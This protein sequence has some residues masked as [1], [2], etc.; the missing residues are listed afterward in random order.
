MNEPGRDASAN[1]PAS[2]PADV[3]AENWQDRLREVTLMMKELSAQTEPQL[4]VQTYRSRIRNLYPA[5]AFVSISRRDLDA[6]RFR[7]TRASVWD[8]D[9]NPW[10]EKHA[11]PI[12][13]RGMLHDLIYAG[14][15][16]Y[17]P[18]VEID[19]DDPAYAY[20]KGKR[21]F[22]A[23]PAYD[24]GVAKNMVVMGRE[25]PDGFDPNELPD[26]V[27]R[28]NL[29]GR[30][31]HTLVLKRELDKAYERVD[32]ELQTVAEIQ[33]S[34]LPAQ[35]PDIDRLDIAAHYE[36]SERA[37]GDYYDVF[38]LANGRWGF[39]IADVCGHGT[40]AAVLMAIT[41]ALAHTAPD[42]CMSPGNLLAYVNDRLSKR[43]TDNG[44]FVTAFYGVF[45]PADLSF[46]YA[47]AGHNPPRVKRCSDGSMFVLN[48]AQSLPL[49]IMEGVEFPEARAELIP[50]D[51]VVLYTD[52]I[53]EAFNDDDELYD[54]RRL[55]D[56]LANC[57]I[58]ARALI[59]SVLDS[60]EAFT[61][62]R[63]ADDDRTLVVLKVR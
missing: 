35:L 24:D 57:G 6:P 43:Y 8:R 51:Q 47:S 58:D 11:L 14:E 26:M 29:F 17:L 31:T 37:G 7:I 61:N 44:T 42:E 34:L 39:L 63:P 36:T 16:T 15:P 1:G 23:I 27:W 40:P 33:R 20:L 25:S 4:M 13:D 41:H 30:A 32:R 55:D 45:D 60:V 53:T 38:P 2:S 56:V 46:V 52:G 9:V 10:E 48:Q 3:V 54:V 22:V 49:G 21:S 28:T 18:N 12:Y 50:G 19:P 59:A 5:D 62:G